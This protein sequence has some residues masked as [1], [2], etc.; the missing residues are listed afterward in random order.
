MPSALDVFKTLAIPFLLGGTIIAGVKAVSTYL[1][2][3]VLASAIGAF[4]S[5]LIAVFFLTQQESIP[6]AHNYFFMN[7]I[8][9]S[10]TA[11]FYLLRTQFNLAKT[12]AL[13]TALGAWF[14][15]A[16][17]RILYSEKVQK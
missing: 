2:N 8:L 6:Y 16:L 1:N 17:A 5:G 14:I 9:L 13:V 4:P 11:I 10:S 3:P 7:L 12:W 15:L